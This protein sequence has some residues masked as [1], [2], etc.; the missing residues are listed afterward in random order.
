MV[1]QLFPIF[2]GVEPQVF[3]LLLDGM[4]LLFLGQ[5]RMVLLISLLMVSLRDQDQASRLIARKIL[6]LL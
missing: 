2:K 1:P 3:D 6:G 5:K 4:A